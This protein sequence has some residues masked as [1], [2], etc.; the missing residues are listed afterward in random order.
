LLWKI[1]ETS[2]CMWRTFK[3]IQFLINSQEMENILIL[4]SHAWIGGNEYQNH[5]NMTLLWNFF[6]QHALQIVR[7]HINNV[8]EIFIFDI[9]ST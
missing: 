8:L 4:Q 3:L 5:C 9:A 7:R 2:Y 1:N 6:Q